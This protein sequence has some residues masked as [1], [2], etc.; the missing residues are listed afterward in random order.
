M[1]RID[2]DRVALWMTLGCGFWAILSFEMELSSKKKQAKRRAGEQFTLE[3][4]NQRLIRIEQH[5]SK[6]MPNDL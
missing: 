3:E 1:N 6:L 5:L 2:I 4:I